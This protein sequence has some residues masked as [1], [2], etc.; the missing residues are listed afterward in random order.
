MATINFLYRSKN[1]EANLSLRFL[2]RDVSGVDH[3]ISGTTK[4]KVSNHY[5]QKQH[6]LKRIRDIDIKTKQTEINSVINI[7]S[8][9]IIKAFN[10]L[11]DVE[12]S[13]VNN[14][15]LKKIIKSFYN[16]N[17][18]QKTTIPTDLISYIKYYTEFRK[19]ELSQNSIKKINVVKHKLERFQD[20]RNKIILIKEVNSNFKKEL[21]DYLI[22][23]NYAPNTITR[24]IRYIKTF[25]YD[26]RYNKI[27]TSH[28]LDKIKTT[29][30]KVK[31]LYLNPNEITLLENTSNL[32]DHLD[33]ARDWL[34]ISCYTGQ[35]ISDFMRFDKGMIEYYENIPLLEF[36]QQKTSKL[37]SI[38]VSGKA[39]VILKKRNGEFPRAISDQR[40]NDYI[41]EVCRIAGI[42]DKVNG[43]KKMETTPGSKKYRKETGIYPKWQLVSSHIG[44]RSFA[45]NYYGKMPTSHIKDITGHSTEKMLLTYI[46]KSDINSALEAS[47]H[48]D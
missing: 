28:Q 38:P 31:P 39:I 17:T 32:I 42:T 4:I 36:T 7:L 20:H 40:Y 3:A 1:K 47:K 15:W 8:K 33:N 43:S 35:R 37:M 2:F 18:E 34:L 48:M 27:E 45:T 19:N 21:E 41:K 30:L 29:Y 14:K 16:P 10:S 9:H 23:E 26:A 6:N 5:W 44:R 46:G 12:A 11:S 13:R 24:D 22:A 25:C